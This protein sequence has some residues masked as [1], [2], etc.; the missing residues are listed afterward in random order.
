MSETQHNSPINTALMNVMVSAVLK[1]AKGLV[2]DFGEVD[3][4]QISRKGVAN[5]VT[6]ADLKC[7][8]ILHTELSKAR[9]KFGFIMEEGGEQDATPL[10]DGAEFYWV[11]DPLDGTTNFIHAVPY[12]CI[13]LGVEK[14]TQKGTEI[15]AGVIYDPIHD[16]L[17]VAEQGK[18]AYMNTRRLRIAP[19][20]EDYY[21]V[22]GTSLIHSEY[23]DKASLITRH[24]VSLQATIRRSGAAALDLAYV[25]AGR[26]DACWFPHLKK[27]DMAAGIALVTEA[28]GRIS[29]LG[30]KHGSAYETGAILA[31]SDAAHTLLAPDASKLTL[32][33]SSS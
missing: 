25:A 18:G 12:F 3:N 20:R 17:Y 24:A 8:K 27:W 14:R 28:G 13:S 22:T 2:R 23:Q 5:F 26:Y 1:A 7:E 9:P 21:F 19:K 30:D 33:K 6:E 29:M 10:D 31:A 32:K 4:L 15:Y 16:E 11:I